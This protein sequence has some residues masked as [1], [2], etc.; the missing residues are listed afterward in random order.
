MHPELPSTVLTLEKKN[1]IFF[2]SIAASIADVY[3][4]LIPCPKF[5]PHL[6]EECRRVLYLM[7]MAQETEYRFAMRR[8][9]ANLHGTLRFSFVSNNTS[10]PTPF[11]RSQPAF[12]YKVENFSPRA[13]TER[14]HVAR[15]SVLTLRIAT[16]RWITAF[17]HSRVLKLD[18]FQVGSPIHASADH[19]SCWNTK[20]CTLLAS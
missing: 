2:S 7:P 11:S 10:Q 18:D 19:L 5:S 15:Q 3:R 4:L 14:I 1:R 17:G 6:H 9:D 12:Q 8:L 16:F 20:S 13:T